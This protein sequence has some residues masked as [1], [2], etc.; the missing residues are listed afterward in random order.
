MNQTRIS[1]SAFQD[2]S[3]MQAAYTQ[4][5]TEK[6]P[7]S[8]ATVRMVPAWSDPSRVAQRPAIKPRGLFARAYSLFGLTF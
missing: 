7:K 1:R 6:A 5:G 2:N 8:A 4:Q 3:D